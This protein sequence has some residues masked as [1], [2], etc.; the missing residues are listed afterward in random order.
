LTGVSTLCV[1][2]VVPAESP[3]TESPPYRDEVDD[4]EQQESSFDENEDEDAFD[5]EYAA[6]FDPR[7]YD[8]AIADADDDDTESVED[9]GQ[10]VVSCAEGLC[11][12]QHSLLPLFFHRIS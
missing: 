4:E 1:L 5:E 7:G 2:C 8:D 9:R 6:Q 10:Y 3:D 11:F 12:F